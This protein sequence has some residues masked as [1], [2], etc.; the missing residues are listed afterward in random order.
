MEKTK[1][2]FIFVTVITCVGIV[3]VI[4]LL[5]LPLKE[6]T[7]WWYSKIL[8]LSLGAFLL[9]LEV[10]SIKIFIRKKKESKI[11]EKYPNLI[12]ECVSS[13]VLALLR[14]EYQQTDE[15]VIKQSGE[16]L[17][18]FYDS[19]DFDQEKLVSFDNKDN[20][21]TFSFDTRTI[22]ISMDK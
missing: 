20:I 8:F 1:S 16:K 6:I 21:L 3:M 2:K 19:D 22:N 18:I 7:A 13:E 9:F 14:K 5:R 10:Q 4:W 15:I 12:F 17:I 11:K